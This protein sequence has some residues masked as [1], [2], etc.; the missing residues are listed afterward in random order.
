M[1]RAV[2]AHV[3][4]ARTSGAGASDDADALAPPAA[5]SAP[6]AAP[7]APRESDEA[8]MPALK[9]ARSFWRASPLDEA[10]G[11]ALGFSSFSILYFSSLNAF[12]LSERPA[13]RVMP[14][15]KLSEPPPPPPPARGVTGVT[16]ARRWPSGVS[17][18]VASAAAIGSKRG[19]AGPDRSSS[20]SA[21]RSA[22]SQPSVSRN[23]VERA[24]LRPGASVRT[25][26]RAG[27]EPTRLRN[28]PF[29]ELAGESEGSAASK[30]ARRFGAGAERSPSACA[31]PPSSPSNGMDAGAQL[32]RGRSTSCEGERSSTSSTSSAGAILT[33]DGIFRRVRRQSATQLAVST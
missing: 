6:P 4:P 17:A 18:A 25:L 2:S 20:S 13:C 27:S 12:A 3:V 9:T 15:R 26:S 23:C 16:L 8:T 5:V 1:M 29:C 32:C 22:S 24:F 11:D 19:I 30:R 10:A 7:S 33:F 21:S 31:A 28:E 14:L